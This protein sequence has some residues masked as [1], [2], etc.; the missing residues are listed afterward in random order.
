[1]EGEV[2]GDLD[3]IEVDGVDGVG[4]LMPVRWYRVLVESQDGD[5]LISLAQGRV[6]V[7]RQKPVLRRRQAPLRVLIGDLCRDADEEGRRFSQ[8]QQP[9]STGIADLPGTDAIE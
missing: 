3:D 4:P 8:P 6:L 9:F 2:G 1:F 7:G 5:R